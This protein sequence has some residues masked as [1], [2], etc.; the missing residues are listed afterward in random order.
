MQI[1]TRIVAPSTKLLR[2]RTR[3][4]GA[5]DEVGWFEDRVHDSLYSGE[6]GTVEEFRIVVCSKVGPRAPLVA[7]SVAEMHRA[8]E[9]TSTYMI[10]PDYSRAVKDAMIHLH[11]ARA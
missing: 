8:F 11:G 6:I 4:V 9:S 1:D 7:R 2:G 10:H 5:M 3:Y